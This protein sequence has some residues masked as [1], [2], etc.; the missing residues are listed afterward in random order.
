MSRVHHVELPYQPPYD[1][2]ASL[3]FVRARHIPG[4]EVVDRE[5]YRR[6]I[7]IGSEQGM[8]RVW[9]QR[10]NRLALE[11]RFPDRRRLPEIVERIRQM[12]DV[13]TDLGPMHRHLAADPILRPVI[14]RCPGLR[15][16]AA[17][18]VFEL[19]VRTILSQ[20]VSLAA[21]MTHAGRLAER[22][23][24]VTEESDELRLFPT[25]QQ[26]ARV[27]PQELRLPRGR[28]RAVVALAREIGH[29]RLLCQLPVEAFESQLLE[30]PGIGPW[31]MQCIRLHGLRC[32]DTFP[33][34]DLAIR[35]VLCRLLPLAT[36][37]QIR[38][39]SLAWSPWS[40]YAT[41]YLWKCYLDG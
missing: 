40:S 13:D 25:P 10:R 35:R 11:V 7:R 14:E 18:D 23:G 27:D 16:I 38:K 17:W 8:L 31:T 24:D 30:I 15:I 19:A 26:L 41:F 37:E 34:T 36:A 2:E 9:P 3:V 39:R 6:T 33:A 28:A 4:V 22:Y 32:R 5:E 21:A 29:G 20:Q 12:F 1:W